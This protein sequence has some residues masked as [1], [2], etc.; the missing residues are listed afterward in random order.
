MAHAEIC[1]VCHGIGRTEYVE[2][3]SSTTVRKSQPC[4]GCDGKGWVEVGNDGI[5]AP[6][7]FPPWFP[8]P[9]PTPSPYRS[10][11]PYWPMITYHYPHDRGL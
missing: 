3:G 10:Y 2:G 8:V 5:S 9:T 1:P 4:H 7:G 11:K 6:Y